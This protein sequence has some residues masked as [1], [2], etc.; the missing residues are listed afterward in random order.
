LAVLLV[1]LA[2][3]AGLGIANMLLR[4]PLDLAAAHNAVAALLLAALV[5]LNFTVFNRSSG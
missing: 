2:L 1:L 5:V 3:Q 4:L